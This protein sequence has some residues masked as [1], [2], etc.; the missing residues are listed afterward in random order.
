MEYI[1]YTH[2]EAIVLLSKT[3][4]IVYDW[5]LT[6]VFRLIEAGLA[7]SIS[8]EV[9]TNSIMSG[10]LLESTYPQKTFPTERFIFTESRQLP[11]K[12]YASDG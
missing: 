1:L 10:Y 2:S 12:L 11:R 3:F 7:K 5:A 8:D 4:V 6:H 9:A